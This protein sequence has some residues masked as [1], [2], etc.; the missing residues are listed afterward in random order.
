MRLA[1]VCAG[2]LV[3]ATLLAGC[4]ASTVEGPDSRLVADLAD[5]DAGEVGASVN[6]FG[7]DLLGELADGDENVIISP[8]SVASVLAMLLAGADGDTAEAIATVLHLDDPRDVRVASLLET[9]FATEDV[10]LTEDEAL[11][12]DIGFPLVDS[13][14]NFVRERF[15]ATLETADLNSKQTADAIDA[16]VKDRTQGRIDGIAKELDLPSPGAVLVLLNSVY[17]LG[18]W[19]TSFPPEAT[20]DRPF[21]LGG[22]GQATVPLMHLAD[23]ELPYAGRDGYQ[24]LRLPYG[25]QERYAMEILLPDPGTSLG[26]LLTS[27]DETEWRAAVESLTDELIQQVAL[28]RFELEWGD[29][30]DQALKALGMGTAYDGGDFRPMS[31]AN[32]FLSTVQHKT[33]LKVNEQGTEAAAAT[34]AVMN[35]CACGGLFLVDRPFAF[36]ISDTQT[37]TILFLGTVTDPRGPNRA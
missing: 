21:T 13:Y 29:G 37:Q 16:W 1:R 34:G 7:F 22:G 5:T 11:W 28:P 14:L 23:Q 20:A 30:L 27:L 2:L 35:M 24:M 12:A 32:P 17:F 19:T 15:G 8:V 9:L 4:A 33:Y 3:A 18:Q 36:T 25:E 6:A 10:T 26:E 31:P